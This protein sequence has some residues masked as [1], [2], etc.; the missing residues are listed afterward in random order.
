MDESEVSKLVMKWLRNNGYKFKTEPNTDEEKNVRLDFYAYKEENGQPTIF[1]IE[2]KG[3]NGLSELLEGWIRVEYAIYHN[4][5]L[6]IF[7]CPNKSA[8]KLLKIK[9]FLSKTVS[10]NIAILDVE[11]MNLIKM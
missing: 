8:N 9:P 7:A 6:G 10:K 3:D 5:G 11:K 4:G 2:C 1:W